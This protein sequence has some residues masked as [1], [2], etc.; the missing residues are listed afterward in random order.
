MADSFDAITTGRPYMPL[1]APEE[2]LAELR[3]Y[4]RAVPIEPGA[5]DVSPLFATEHGD[6][7]DDL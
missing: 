5:A 6:G 1:R 2:G 4:C 7:G 3:R